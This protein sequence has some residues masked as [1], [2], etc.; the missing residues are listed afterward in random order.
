MKVKVGISNRHVH[1]TKSDFKILFGDT[2]LIPERPLSQ[3]G[4]YASNLK[5]TIKTPKS[6]I[7]GVRVMY[8]LRDYTQTEIS[9]TDSYKLGLNPPVRKSGELENSETITLIGPNGTITTN[10]VIIACRHIHMNPTEAS[11]YGYIDNQLVSVKIDGEK[12]GTL[13]NVS[14]KIKDTYVLEIHL[15]TDD[16]NAFMLKSGDEVTII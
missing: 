5:L 15:D 13:D 6:E 2:E 4:E 10:G 3:H 8:P 16:A 9:K 11:N 14:I 1:L 12:G 7:E